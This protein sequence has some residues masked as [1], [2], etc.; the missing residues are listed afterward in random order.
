M[1]GVD[2]LRPFLL[3]IMAAHFPASDA[4]ITAWWDWFIANNQMLSDGDHSLR[5]LAFT[6]VSLANYVLPERHGDAFDKALSILNVS[7]DLA[8]K[9][10]AVRSLLDGLAERLATLRSERLRAARVDPAKLSIFRDALRRELLAQGPLLTAFH[11]YDIRQSNMR[12]TTMQTHSFGYLCRVELAA[13][14]V[15][16]SVRPY[17]PSSLVR[18]AKG[19]LSPRRSIM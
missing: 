3:A 6:L 19:S 2:K 17:R 16:L 15:S 14:R 7:A 4:P 1:G 8:A 12:G 10:T 5:N 11:S 13:C 18:R 9:R